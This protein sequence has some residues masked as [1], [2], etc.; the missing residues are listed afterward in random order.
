MS[1]LFSCREAVRLANAGFDRHLSV[2]ERTELRLHLLMCGACRAY[3]RQV[4]TLERLIR[5]HAR[6]DAGPDEGL[7]PE[8]RERIRR[9]LR[10]G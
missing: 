10:G 4:A 8:A 6:V 3:G 9:A 2:R 7:S 1:A 5:T